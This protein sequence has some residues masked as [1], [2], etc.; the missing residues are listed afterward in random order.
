MRNP[1]G[2]EI[3]TGDWSDKSDLWTDDL[4][5]QVGS[6]ETNDGVFFIDI[7][8]YMKD[9]GGTEYAMYQDWHRDWLNAMWDR[10]ESSEATYAFKNTED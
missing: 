2:S 10:P 6:T 3:Y 5:K 4:R 7:D 9:F 8:S 1:W